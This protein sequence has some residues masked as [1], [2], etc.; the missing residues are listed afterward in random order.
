MVVSTQLLVR[1]DNCLLKIRRTQL[2]KIIIQI[3]LVI[4]GISLITSITYAKRLGNG[5]GLE[6]SPTLKIVYDSN[7]FKYSSESIDDFVSGKDYYRYEAIETYDDL[8]FIQEAKIY[9]SKRQSRNSRSRLRLSLEQNSYSVNEQK[10]YFSFSAYFR[11]YWRKTHFQIG[12]FIIPSYHIRY[13]YDVDTKRYE[14]CDY[15]KQIFSAKI[16]HPILWKAYLELYY[17]FQKD[18]YV[19][20]FDEYDTD[21]NIFEAVL[22]RHINT[23]LRLEIKYALQQAQAKA[24][25]ESNENY[26][27]SDDSDI[28][29]DAHTFEGQIQ[30]NIRKTHQLPIRI[31]LDFSIENRKY[32]TDKTVEQ[33]PYHS[34]RTDKIY[35]AGIT[36]YTAINKRWDL[37]T[38]YNID[39]R[40]VSSDYKEY[41][42]DVKDYTKNRVSIS[43]NFHY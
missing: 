1:T 18:D 2:R 28:S 3:I 39:V 26:S 27:N 11:Q 33:D 4:F 12:Y 30:W 21:I 17:K 14:S 43:A 13:I 34:G 9:L 32:T 40:K 8:I 19:E 5:W 35:T 38:G 42:D 6:I 24:A 15:K 36:F 22:S 31:T 16:F 23:N 25:D 37:E 29:Y 41:I 10:D 20:N 7:I